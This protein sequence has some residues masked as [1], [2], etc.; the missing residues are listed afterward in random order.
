MYIPDPMEMAEKMAEKY[1]DENCDEDNIKC[2]H[3]K[4]MVP[5]VECTPSSEHPCAPPMCK[6]CAEG[7]EKSNEKVNGPRLYRV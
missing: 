7:E 2:C 6:E 3:C 1:A 5:I 4:K